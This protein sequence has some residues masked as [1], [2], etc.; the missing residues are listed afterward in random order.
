MIAPTSPD[1]GWWTSLANPA[2]T[3]WCGRKPGTDE[4]ATTG[5]LTCERT[6]Y[7][8]GRLFEVRVQASYF[9][10]NDDDDGVFGQE[11]PTVSV[12]VDSYVLTPDQA[13]AL[14]SQ[15][16]AAVRIFDRGW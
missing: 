5:V 8:D 6:V 13:H 9:V 7:D 2:C 15:V 3:T 14:A 10:D 16:Q 4:F 12:H 1:N 11:G